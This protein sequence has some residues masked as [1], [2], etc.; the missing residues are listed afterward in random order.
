VRISL[1]PDGWAQP[2]CYDPQSA[3]RTPNLDKLASQGM[4]FTEGAR[5]GNS[6][7]GKKK[8]DGVN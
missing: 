6:A 2:Q 7:K 5:K 3:L 8:K 4:R 1:D